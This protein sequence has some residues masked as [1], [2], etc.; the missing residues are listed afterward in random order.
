MVLE[1]LTKCRRVDKLLH[2]PNAL[3]QTKLVVYMHLKVLCNIL[4]TKRQY[5]TQTLIALKSTA[6]I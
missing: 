4:R 2:Q 1:S 3:F 6:A 5:I